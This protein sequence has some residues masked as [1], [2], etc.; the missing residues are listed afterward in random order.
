MK[1]SQF[2]IEAGTGR[3][4]G[5]PPGG[6]LLEKT[7]DTATAPA[8]PFR[9][10][11]LPEP[12]APAGNVDA[13]ERVIGRFRPLQPQLCSTYEPYFW[14]HE[15][16]WKVTDH[17]LNN[18]NGTPFKNLVWRLLGVRPPGARWGGNPAT[19]SRALERAT[20][21]EPPRAALGGLV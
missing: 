4:M 2:L 1:K 13:A 6:V 12:D 21:H 19:E 8:G 17:Y 18:F 7:T 14:W 20:T 15:R 3:V 5:L 16:L 11:R 9:E 10:D